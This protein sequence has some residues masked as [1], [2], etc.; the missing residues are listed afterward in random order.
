MM[1]SIQASAVNKYYC[2]PT[3]TPREF[4]QVRTIKT[5]LSQTVL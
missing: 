2:G 1:T 5:P 3:V 4:F